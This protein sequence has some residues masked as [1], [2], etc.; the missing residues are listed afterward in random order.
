MFF[1][2]DAR[3]LR[4][5]RWNKAG[6][7]TIGLSREEL[8]GKTDYDVFPTEEADFF[9]GKDREA[10]N[11]GKLVDTPEEPVHTRHKGVRILHTLKVPILDAQGKPQYLVGISDDITERKRA[12]EEA[13]RTQAFLDSVV[14]NIPI[15]VF[16]KEAKDLK[17]VLWNRAGEETVGYSREEMIGKTDHDFFTKEEADFFH[18][19][20]REALA[21]GSLVDTP[22]EPIHTHHKGIRLLHTLK[23]PIRDA[24][25]KPQYLMGISE[26]ITERKRAEEEAKRTQAFLDSV[27][28]NTPD[29]D[30]R[31]RCRRSQVRALEQGR[32]G[33]DRFLQRGHDRQHRL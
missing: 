10:L 24:D 22:E 5:V 27:V 31:E 2:K 29:H 23:V 32:R 11:S 15:M 21:A 6:A 14:E 8:I 33:V 7:E 16:V 25:G 19:R 26:D 28:E 1:V 18:A 3:D 4:W 13:S 30:L 17:W 12:E 20:D 9:T